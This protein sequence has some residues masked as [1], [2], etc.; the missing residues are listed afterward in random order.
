MS[1]SDRRD[2]AKN[3][4]ATP[5]NSNAVGN[6]LL[7][8]VTGNKTSS[9]QRL[10]SMGRISS[11]VSGITGAS[12]IPTGNQDDSSEGRTENFDSSQSVGN[13]ADTG[14]DSVSSGDNTD[15]S[16]KVAIEPEEPKELTPTLNDMKSKSKNLSRMSEQ[17]I[18][19]EQTGAAVVVRTDGQINL[20]AS[21]YSSYKL[22]P[23]GKVTEQS[24]ESEKITNRMRLLTDEII[25]NEH[26]MNPQLWELTDFRESPLLSNKH[27]I[28]GGFTLDGHVLVKAW[29][30]QLKRYMLIRRPWRGPM[31][32]PILNVPEINSAIRVDDPLKI[33][34]DILALSDK[35]Y[36]VSTI[37]KD[38][39]SLIGKAG[40][41]RPGIPRNVDA[42]EGTDS[43]NAP[44]SSSNSSAS[45]PFK[46]DPSM[47]VGEDDKHCKK[48]NGAGKGID[49]I[50]SDANPNYVAFAKAASEGSG[51][52]VDWIY[53]QLI[54]ESGGEEDSRYPYNY[55]NIRST[56]GPW[57]SYA[58]PE[59][60]GHYFGKYIR[61][62][63]SP[64]CTAAH[65]LGEYIWAIQHQSNS[66][67]GDSPYE[68]S[69]PE[70]YEAK[71]TA[72]GLNGPS[73]KL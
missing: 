22:S 41:D 47:E 43:G 42:M 5:V 2:K 31:F 56:E 50:P 66:N 57:M 28:I 3:L 10:N 6:K 63:N 1:K 25:I 32:G 33:N 40:V 20:A 68:C 70:G 34:D 12:A 14:S 64:P 54:A 23:K 67:N 8:Q 9:S 36:Q 44:S 30:P 29:E 51:L 11:L 35:G 69:D 26:K 39:K 21:K 59:D 46:W 55:G 61:L 48:A 16:I 13:N 7:G 52:P 37:I 24:M 15:G 27:A 73:T 49:N 60:A 4:L 18:V 72:I 38:S 17:G 53:A 45:S 62:Y 58:S 71:V 65:T 19:N